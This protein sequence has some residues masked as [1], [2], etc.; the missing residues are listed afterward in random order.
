MEGFAK[1]EVIWLDEY[2]QSLIHHLEHHDQ[3]EDGLYL[4]KSRYEAQKSS[5]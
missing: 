3:T 1:P 4:V 2:G 5:S